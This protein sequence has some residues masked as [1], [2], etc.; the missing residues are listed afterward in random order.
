MPAAEGNKHYELILTP[1]SCEIPAEVRLQRVL[2]ALL[3]SY[4]FRCKSVKAVELKKKSAKTARKA[5]KQPR[6]SLGERGPTPARSNG[7]A[8]SLS[9]QRVRSIAPQAD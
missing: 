5:R 2:K 4:R 1:L 9:P 7:E 8:L 3:R 6:K